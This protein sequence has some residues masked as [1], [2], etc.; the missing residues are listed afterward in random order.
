MP[1]STCRNSMLLVPINE[2]HKSY[3][4]L[5]SSLYSA[6]GY[7]NFAGFSTKKGHVGTPETVLD[8]NSVRRVKCYSS[9]RRIEASR[10]STVYE[11]S[12]NKITA[13]LNDI[14][15]V[16]SQWTNLRKTA[17]KKVRA[18][19]QAAES[20]R[21]DRFQVL[22]HDVQRRKVAAREDDTFGVRLELTIETHSDFSFLNDAIEMPSVVEKR[23][24]MTNTEFESAFE[25]SPEK[26]PWYTKIPTREH[27]QV[28]DGAHFELS[29][30]LM[31]VTIQTL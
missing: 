5:N 12:A 14:N 18:K 8:P 25:A 7:P 11:T 19:A 3:R 10:G 15:T 24:S 1:T 22:L 17:D 23:Q 4:Q 6:P 20:M 9:N 2:S 16:L 13:N 21:Q 28:S 31:P 26:W 30:D 27:L 29:S